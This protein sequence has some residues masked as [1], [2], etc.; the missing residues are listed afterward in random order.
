MALD[1]LLTAYPSLQD[2]TRR[3]GG[4]TLFARR[5]LRS[6]LISTGQ[7]GFYDTTN[8]VARESVIFRMR[9][10]SINLRT[11]LVD[12]ENNVW[13]LESIAEVGRRR[14]LDVA[15]TTY[16]GVS[17]GDDLATW[18]PVVDNYVA[19]P[20]WLLV[21]GDNNPVQN[22][23]I[24]QWS[25]NQDGDPTEP[26]LV[27][28]DVLTDPP[29]DTPEARAAAQTQARRGYYWA[30]FHFVNDGYSGSLPTAASRFGTFVPVTP[31]ITYIRARSGRIGRIIAPARASGGRATV[32]ATDG[33][34]PVEV[35]IQ[36]TFDGII[37][38]GLQVGQSIHILSENDPDVTRPDDG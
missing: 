38:P 27:A 8:L 18:P 14:F 35:G 20:N 13:L 26:T 23:V 30:Q 3:S 28:P 12:N 33:W 6:E 5:Q 32:I 36:V 4:R 24:R 17:V 29:G 15:A 31:N 11:V 1:R 9:F 21:D 16:R 10:Q 34:I 19:Q 7:T 22:I 25:I 37:N 2:A